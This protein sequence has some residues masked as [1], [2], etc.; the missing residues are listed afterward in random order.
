MNY[1]HYP[2]DPKQLEEAA[3]RFPALPQPGNEPVLDGKLQRINNDIR[4]LRYIND[5]G[6]L[7]ITDL[8]VLLWPD[9]KDKQR[10]AYRL[11]RRWLKANYVIERH[12]EDLG[13]TIL[14]L[15]G[16]GAGF[17]K[18]FGLDHAKSGS[19]WGRITNGVWRPS[20]N[21]RHDLNCTTIGI[22]LMLQG[23]AIMTEAH[24]RNEFRDAKPNKW[25]DMLVRDQYDDLYW[26]EV[27]SARKSGEHMDQM[28]Q[29]LINVALGQ[30]EKLLNIEAIP[31]VAFI[32]QA[33]DPISGHRIDHLTRVENAIRR[34]TKDHISLTFFERFQSHFYVS[35]GT[36][37][38]E[39]D[40]LIRRLRLMERRGWEEYEGFPDGAMCVFNTTGHDSRHILGFWRST[41]QQDNPR[42]AWKVV[43][44]AGIFSGRFELV[45]KGTRPLETDMKRYLAQYHWVEEADG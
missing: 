38:I 3:E 14:V 32:E 19:D 40:F 7:R 11:V 5:F 2:F 42:W 18:T 28:A 45:N 23:Y 1:S 20:K 8:G 17:L 4:G 21:W 37:E 16:Q 33:R 13:C 31:A 30:M 10:N 36:S 44:E 26:V 25:P 6:W 43:K 35:Q 27:E 24:I 39:P 22:S 41:D 12:L 15:S 29:T 9:A 34:L